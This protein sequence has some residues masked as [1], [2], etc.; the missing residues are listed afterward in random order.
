ML[1]PL[2][3]RMCFLC[4]A[5]C[6]TAVALGAAPAAA[7]LPQPIGL[8]GFGALFTP[9]ISPVKDPVT[10]MPRMMI[11]CDMGDAFMSEDGGSHWWMIDMKQLEGNTSCYPAFDP[12]DA[13]T[14]YAADV[15]GKGL[16]VS[17]DGGHT[18]RRYGTSEDTLGSGYHH[19]TGRITVNAD[20]PDRTVIVGTDNSQVWITTDNGQTWSQCPSVTGGFQNA[21][22]EHASPLRRMCCFVCT[23]RGIW[24]SDDGGK[25][26]T[27]CVSG[28]PDGAALQGFAGGHSAR[29][30]TI[31]Y[32]AVRGTVIN[33][34][35]VGG[36][37]TSTD[38]G[39]SWS[40]V[41]GRGLNR[42]TSK[43]GMGGDY[44][45]YLAVLAMDDDPARVWA[46]CQGNDYFGYHH[47]TYYYST[48]G[49]NKWSDTFWADPKRDHAH[50][51]NCGPCEE[52]AEHGYYTAPDHQHM[53]IC[54]SDANWCVSSDW[55][56]EGWVTHKAGNTWEAI[57]ARPLPGDP[58]PYNGQT[59]WMCNGLT[60]TTCWDFKIDPFQPDR[61]YVAYT[62]FGVYLSSDAGASW[63]A[64]T[65]RGRFPWTNTC[66][67]LACDPA[68]P[69]LVYG[70][71][72]SMHD[73]NSYNDI[74]GYQGGMYDGN[75]G[76]VGRSDDS[77]AT[78]TACGSG[79][80][81]VA[82]TSVILDPD[83]PVKSR[84]LYAAMFTE[85]IYKSVD[86]GAVWSKMPGKGLPF[87][88]HV[89]R[90]ALHKDGTLLAHVTGRAVGGWLKG[91]GVYRY[92]TKAGVWNCLTAGVPTRDR[93]PD[94]R[95][96]W[97]CGF[98]VDPNDSRIVYV[99]EADNGNAPG[100]Y[101]TK[102]GG[103]SWTRILSIDACSGIG[104]N[105]AHASWLYVTSM[106][107][108]ASAPLW[109]SKDSGATF[110]PLARLPF[111][112][113]TRP[114]VDPHDPATLYLMTF[115]GGAWKCP[116]A[117]SAS[118]TSPLATQ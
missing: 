39:V 18:W 2:N 89:V 110:A 113:C 109:I 83:S 78:W 25:N 28:I 36:I 9:A 33:K 41:K 86:G 115:G 88:P 95:L 111:Q 35:Y 21:Y 40:L 62:D 87:N 112:V 5:A 56:G 114:V 117:P 53:A 101:R 100:L 23:S 73:I 52:V 103:Q 71:F 74:L 10:G 1:Q 91:A 57:T 47:T 22:I 14:I 3:A 96:H 37:Y 34:A 61:R 76:G 80:P 42:S 63:K 81:E 67:Q 50:P 118:Q 30:G 99:T 19:L 46:Y 94:T 43:G 31:L 12:K 17:T 68:V 48:D 7:P 51:G 13:K 108:G 44:P 93:S 98:A 77:C 8:S 70:G 26:W 27:S 16:K 29:A 107:R 90:V 75:K 11:D 6:V 65:T 84:T 60:D 58:T 24:R 92:D 54:A 79:L 72:S 66:Y 38:L 85:G 4:L 32:C 106:D 59:H 116:A 64:W 97:P 20:Q 105:P 55:F 15:Q 82:C 102:D 69:G 45:Q 49:G 104:F